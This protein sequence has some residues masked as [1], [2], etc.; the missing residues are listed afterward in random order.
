MYKLLCDYATQFGTD[1]PVSAIKDNANA[2]EA[3]RIIQECLETGI[4]Y[5]PDTPEAEPTSAP[6]PE[7]EPE[8]EPEQEPEPEPEEKPVKKTRTKKAK[9]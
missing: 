6:A 8:P 7:P 1:F 5:H 4:P 2:Y 3:V 9:T